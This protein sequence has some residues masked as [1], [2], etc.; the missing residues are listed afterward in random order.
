MDRRLAAILAADIVGYSQL[1]G[2]DEAGK[3]APHC[4]C[5]LTPE[6]SLLGAEAAAPKRVHHLRSA[7]QIQSFLE[8][9]RK[10]IRTTA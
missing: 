9:V 5:N 8:A 10:E 2:Q 1:M 7:A 4:H 6:Y 3:L